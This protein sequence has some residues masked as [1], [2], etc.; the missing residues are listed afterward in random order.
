MHTVDRVTK[1]GPSQ[2]KTAGATKC[3]NLITQ[4]PVWGVRLAVCAVISFRTTNSVITFCTLYVRARYMHLISIT[5]QE[6]GA[7]LA[8]CNTNNLSSVTHWQDLS[9]Y[10]A[11]IS[12]MASRTFSLLIHGEQLKLWTSWPPTETKAASP[13][14]LVPPEIIYPHIAGVNHL[15]AAWG[16]KFINQRKEE[17]IG[18]Q[19]GFTKSIRKEI[20]LHDFSWFCS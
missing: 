12:L 13:W 9:F 7:K 18:M 15:V 6:I 17:T 10:R 20:R 14:G 5:L 8:Q 2:I 11:F 4:N 1:V 3:W 19:F 16:H